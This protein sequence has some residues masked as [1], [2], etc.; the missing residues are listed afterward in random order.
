MHPQTARSSLQRSATQDFAESGRQLHRQC[1]HELHV[2]FGG[3]LDAA[4][5]HHAQ[6]CR[7]WAQAILSL[8]RLSAMPR[9]QLRVQISRGN[10][11]FRARQYGQSHRRGQ[12]AFPACG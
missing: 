8:Q 5:L 1:S 2:L 12:G 10:S 9:A 6:A 7:A 4:V 3:L 11:D